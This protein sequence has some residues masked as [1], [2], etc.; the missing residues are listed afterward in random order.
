M[1]Y[2]DCLPHSRS[3]ME[4]IQGLGRNRRNFGESGFKISDLK[5]IGTNQLIKLRSVFLV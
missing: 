4:N 5:L 3:K 2:H 1:K